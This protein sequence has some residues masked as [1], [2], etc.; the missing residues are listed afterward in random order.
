VYLGESFLEGE[1]SVFILLGFAV[2]IFSV[3]LFHWLRKLLRQR[4]ES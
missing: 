3:F 1:S 4:D 2:I